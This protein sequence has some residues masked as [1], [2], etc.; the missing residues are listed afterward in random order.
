MLL[1]S[2]NRMAKNDTINSINTS[3]INYSP[4]EINQQIES[5]RIPFAVDVFPN[6]NSGIFTIEVY[7]Y[8]P[9]S[10]EIINS[11][12]AQ[13]YKVEHLNTSK[14]NL[15]Q[16]GLP[17]GVYYIRILHGNEIVFKKLVIQ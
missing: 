11:L 16:T 12:G 7:N 2:G 15:N 6:P 8:K 4:K 17:S 13:L 1:L 5:K 10:I 3:L 9:Y 14:I